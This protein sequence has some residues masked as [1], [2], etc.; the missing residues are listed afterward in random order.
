MDSHDPFGYLTHKLWPKERSR[1]KLVVWLLIT[2][3]RESPWLPCVQ[4]ACHI[5]LKSFWW[6][7]QLCFRPHL[8]R[9][10]EHKVIGPQ[11]CRDPN[12]GNFRTPT[13]ESWDKWHLVAGPMARHRECYK[14]EASGF[15]Q[16]RAMVSLL[17]SCLPMIHPC[18]K[19]AQTTH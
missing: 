6:R 17:N 1:V 9:R 4:V 12:L 15:P 11:S 5:L 19:S 13:W 8:N 10:F 18:T 14:I 3:S 16:V 7:L 2:K